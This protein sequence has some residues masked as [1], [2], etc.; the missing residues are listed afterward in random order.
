M[1]IDIDDLKSVN[2]ELG[3]SFGDSALLTVARRAGRDLQ[4]GETLAR[5]GGDQFG[6]VFF[7]ENG[8]EAGIRAEGMRAAL[9]APISFGDR[10]VSLTASIGYVVFDPALHTRAIDLYADAELALAN[11]KKE[12]GDRVSQFSREMRG[13][14]KAESSQIAELRGALDRGEF[15]VLYQP[16]VRLEDRTVAG[17]EALLRW[18]HPRLG[19]LSF[20]DFLTDAENAGVLQQIGIFALDSAT[21][22]LAAWQKALEVNP[23]IFATLNITSRAFMSGDLLGD[24]RSALTQRQLLRNSLKLEFSESVVMENPE[25]SAQLLPR[26]RDIG[27]G[28]AIRDF[29]AGNT[30]LTHLE[31]F[32]F[33]TLKIAPSLAKPNA[34][35]VRPVVLRSVIA[36]AHDLG[37]DA[38]V[39]GVETESDAVAL[40]QL[41]CEFAEGPAFG[42]PMTAAQARKLMG[43]SAE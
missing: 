2:S 32:R 28:L 36:L 25:F 12:G 14:R 39:E 1:A 4:P 22:E 34:S 9:A 10:E 27:A 33:D 29:G 30:S 43:A 24:L 23:P 6:V 31:R 19:L 35:G 26:A 20:S 37:M 16:I 42:Q 5:L 8:A 18:R 7:L 38:I 3:L 13:Q 11:A 40:A 15:V 41:G 21:K 17:F